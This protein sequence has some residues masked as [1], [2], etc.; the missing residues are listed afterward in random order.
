M[1]TLDRLEYYRARYAALH[2]GWQSATARYQALVAATLTPTL[3]VL[4]LG[5]GRGGIAERLYTTAP[6]IG[7]DPDFCSLADHR[8]TTLPRGQATATHLP[9]PACTFDLVVSSWV[10]EHVA[11]PAQ[12]FNE[13]ARVLRTGGRFIFLTP[14]ARH[15]IPRLSQLL[16]RMQQHL[17]PRIYG[18][19]TA[20]AFPVHYQAN[21]FEQ[22][23]P[24]ATTAGLRLVQMEF[25]DDP[26]YW[27]WNLATFRL[28]V[29]LEY[30][31]PVR[32]KV[33]LIGEYIR[34]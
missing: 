1:S 27:A 15:P 24:L 18:R 23:A 7:I 12:T 6:W 14:N 33:H 25:V 22:I 3:K 21:T 9:F 30:L 28:A 26:S 5:C 13:V 34:A 10:L 11:D 32:W 20:D 4:D 2:P 16:A 29:G 17:V 31:L 8:V 19:D